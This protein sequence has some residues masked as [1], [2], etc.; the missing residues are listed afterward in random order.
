MTSKKYSNKLYI[1]DTNNPNYT[2]ADNVLHPFRIKAYK[3]YHNAMLR[4]LPS[5]KEKNLTTYNNYYGRGIKFNFSSFHEFVEEIGFPPTKR[6]QLDRINN[7][8][9]YEPGNIRWILPKGNQANTRISR[10]ITINGITK[11]LSWFALV[12]GISHRA[13]IKRLNQGWPDHLLLVPTRHFRTH[14]NLIEKANDTF[15]YDDGLPNMI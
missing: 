5:M 1:E 2:H 14:Y 8:G 3:A 7:D 11:P 15:G 6:H 13:L 10:T 12:Y 4:C 9:N